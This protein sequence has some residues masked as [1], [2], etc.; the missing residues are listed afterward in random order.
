MRPTAVRHG[1]GGGA[2]RRHRVLERSG[3]SEE[4]GK[5]F[6]RMEVRVPTATTRTGR[7]A[8]QQAKVDII[9]QVRRSCTARG[10]PFVFEDTIIQMREW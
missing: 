9:F 10:P 1:S 4:S 5:D 7:P 3:K 6:A 8:S 2:I